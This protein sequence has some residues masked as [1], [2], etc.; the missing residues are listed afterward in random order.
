MSGRHLAFVLA[1]GAC[2]DR[3]VPEPPAAEDS[4]A[5]EPT[6]DFVTDAAWSPEGQRLVLTWDR[7]D[8]ARLYRLLGPTPDGTVPEPSMGLPLG[9]G[10]GE[11]ATWAPDGLWIAYGSGGDIVRIRPDGTGG[12][13]LT[14]GPANDTDP[15]YAPDGTRIVFVSDRGGEGERLWMMNA[16]GGEP[17]PMNETAPGT[18]NRAPAW[19][20]DGRAIA[21]TADEGGVEVVYVGMP[22][23]G[24]PT[25]LG[26][27][28]EP[29]WSPDGA[30][31]YF[32]RRDSVFWRPAQGGEPRFVLA[33]GS[34]PRVAP[35]GRWL[36]FVRG[37]PPS[38]ALWLL[39]LETSSETR[40]TP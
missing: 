7:G 26:E 8:G 35:D 34:T 24:G 15:E 27:G 29:D 16:G 20:P 33:D 14:S 32:E 12:E 6:P 37:T 19:S 30:R 40:I 39:D 22:G 1:L 13:R 5:P 25:R 36:S 17:T 11:G 38:S 10:P 28:S 18:G 3:A 21:F 23:G 4:V 2:A 31:I 9:R